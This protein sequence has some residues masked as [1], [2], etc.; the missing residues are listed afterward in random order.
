MSSGGDAAGSRPWGRWAARQLDC[1]FFAIAFG[2][3]VSFSFQ[4]ILELPD[5]VFGM[6]ILVAW[7][8]LEAVFLSVA[9]TTPGKWLLSIRVVR[10]DGDLLSLATAFAR[11]LRV[12]FWGMGLGIPV[13]NLLA[14]WSG[15]RQLQESGVASWDRASGTHVDGAVPSRL[16]MV[17]GAVLG[18]ACLGFVAYGAYMEDEF[19]QE[20]LA[21]LAQLRT[22]EQDAAKEVGASLVPDAEPVVGQLAHGGWAEYEVEVRK[23]TNLVVMAGCDMDCLDLDLALMDGNGEEI[24]RD[25][26]EDALPL[27]GATVA[28]G[29]YTVRVEMY[30]CAAGPCTFAYQRSHADFAYWRAWD[31]GTC[32]LVHPEGLA[33]TAGHVVERDDTFAVSFADGSTLPGQVVARSAD[34]DLAVLRVERPAESFLPLARS[35]TPGDRVFTFGFPTSEM[36]GYEPKYSEGTVTARSG[37]DERGVLLQ[38][39]VPIQPGNSGGPLVNLRGEAVGVMVSTATAEKFLQDYGAIPQNVNFAVKSDA[40]RALVDLPDP[41]P[42]AASREEAIQRARESVCLVRHISQLEKETPA[43]LSA[44]T[45]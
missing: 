14:N 38:T 5:L 37:L 36:L 26:Y 16:R 2:V 8:P 17:L 29:S 31:E 21:E 12:W 27:V 22:A 25:D 42:A 18:V 24:V 28:P 34:D 43:W 30:D 13:V 23:E 44:S 41:P 15:Y 32:F 40:A 39:T 35:G 33:L 6:V 1:L 11:S 7:V 19:S 3:A 9:G 4:R 20:A 45:P 10:P